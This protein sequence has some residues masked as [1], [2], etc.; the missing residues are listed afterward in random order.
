MS[1]IFIFM[2]GLGVS[3]VVLASTIISLIATDFPNDHKA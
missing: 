3:G 2:V 1:D